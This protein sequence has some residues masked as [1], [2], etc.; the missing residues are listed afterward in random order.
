MASGFHVDYSVDLHQLMNWW[1]RCLEPKI[2]RPLVHRGWAASLAQLGRNSDPP[3]S[4]WKSD[5]WNWTLGAVTLQTVVDCLFVQYLVVRSGKAFQP[6]APV[7][8][9]CRDVAEVECW[10]V[11]CS[12]P[13]GRPS[14][15]SKGWHN[16]IYRGF[17][18]IVKGFRTSANQKLIQN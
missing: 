4:A 1:E 8:I 17:F 6:T 7:A 14:F 18:P 5:V 10:P 12:G 15:L 9:L 2:I 3:Y 13:Q 16:C 11:T